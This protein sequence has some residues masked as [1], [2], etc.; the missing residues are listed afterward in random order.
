LAGDRTVTAAP[1]SPRLPDRFVAWARERD[2]VVIAGANQALKY[3]RRIRLGRGTRDHPFEGTQSM[4]AAIA[5]RELSGTG[6]RLLFA[7]GYGRAIDPA[8][9]YFYRSAGGCLYEIRFLDREG[10]GNRFNYSEPAAQ[11][12]ARRLE[13]TLADTAELSR[14]PLL[15]VGCSW[16]AAVID[17]ALTHGAGQGLS[18]PGG[19]VAIGGPRH[20]FAPRSPLRPCRLRD[21]GDHGNLWVQR[22]PDD[23][24]GKGGLG[25]LLYFRNTR[26]HDYRSQWPDTG[27]WGIS[28]R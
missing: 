19:G 13:R 1:P 2:I 28:G 6:K 17:Y 7:W 3:W 10:I 9:A 12:D 5:V 4:E 18:L 11:V 15:F 27:V 22:H 25:P 23:P 16:G 24:I 26:L 20:L 14:R 8:R 21:N